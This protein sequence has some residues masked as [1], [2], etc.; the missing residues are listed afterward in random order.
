MDRQELLKQQ[1]ELFDQT[2]DNFEK[3]LEHGQIDED[4]FNSLKASAYMELQER[5]AEIMDV[6]EEDIDGLVDKESDEEYSDD[7][8]TAN[9]STDSYY[10]SALLELAKQSDYDDIEQ[11]CIDLAEATGYDAND[12]YGVITGELEPT[13][14][15]TLSVSNV[16]DLD[17]ELEAHLLLAGMEERGEDIEELLAEEDDLETED[18]Y[19]ESDEEYSVRNELAEFKMQ[20]LIKDELS[21]LEDRCFSLVD[22]GKM[23]PY[24]AEIL[25][26]NHKEKD[27]IAAFSSLCD[28]NSVAP[29]TQLF[30]LNTVLK[31]FEHMP[32]IEF[33]YYAEQSKT[34]EEL[35]ED[36]DLRGIASNWVKEFRKQQPIK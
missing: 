30:A 35:D 5:T 33:G 19:E 34:T 17:E 22:E 8:E 12:V 24:V 31:V 26:G 23:P 1:M 14:E 9:F 11:Y 15:F 7:S 32:Q 29:E 36:N 28:K 6:Q 10:G 18:E 2:V 13:D 20:S 27:K 3:M 21:E 4:E 25:L 16:F